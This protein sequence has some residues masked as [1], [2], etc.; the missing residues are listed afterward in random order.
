MNQQENYSHET[1]KLKSKKYIT[2]F[3]PDI[4][5]ADEQYQDYLWNFDAGS[6]FKT[7][8]D[9]IRSEWKE[10]VNEKDGVTFLVFD[11]DSQN[12]NP[13]LVAYY[14][15]C[16]GTIP[17]TDRWFIPEDERD[18]SGQTYDEKEYGIPTVEIKMFA[19]SNDYQDTFFEDK[20][21][22]A[23]IIEELISYIRYDLTTSIISAK[24]I[25]L[26]SVPSAESFYLRNGFQYI[27]TYM[28]PLHS[29]DSDLKA[30]FFPLV[31]LRIHYDP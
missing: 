20:P 5:L 19:V 17:Y 18:E 31:E 2:H 1:V 30:M 4:V 3:N 21:I 24:A 25:F 14:T 12:T 22:S 10:Y 6:G 27:H 11:R 28:H 23:W 16:T 8:N 13:K 29:I 15:L 9:F 26:H 7:F